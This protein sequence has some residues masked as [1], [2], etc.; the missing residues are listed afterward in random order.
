[1]GFCRGDYF[2]VIE[3]MS[4]RCEAL[5]EEILG[6]PRRDVLHKTH[7]LKREL[8]RLRR[9]I[10][11][12]REMLGNLLRNPSPFFSEETR[13]YLRDIHDHAIHLLEQLEDLRELLTGLLDVYLNS[14]SNRL[15][16]EVHTLT[17]LTTVF[18]PA[19]LVTGSFGM[20]FQKM[21]WL[22]SPDGFSLALMLMA[23]VAFAL[24]AALRLRRLLR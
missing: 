10:W 20:N 3:H 23:G 13:L 4:D 1:M 7:A 9:T 14:V 16:Q 8:S 5:E 24:F 15:N 12:M 19:T 2:N 22:E 17:L 18:M 6:K 21:P 11:P